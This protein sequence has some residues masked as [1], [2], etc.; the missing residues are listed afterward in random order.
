MGVWAWQI[1]SSPHPQP[2][3][4]ALGGGVFFS[5]TLVLTGALLLKLFA[6][7]DYNLRTII[8]LGV[9]HRRYLRTQ[10]KKKKKKEI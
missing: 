9:L 7:L 1:A 10:L 8:H 4:L 3:P 5:M 2:Q 6:F